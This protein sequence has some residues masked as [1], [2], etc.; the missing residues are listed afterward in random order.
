MP[1]SFAVPLRSPAPSMPSSRQR[2]NSEFVNRAL[3]KVAP[4]RSQFASAGRAETADL[5]ALRTPLDAPRPIV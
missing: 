3:E 5:A 2:L 1:S 4:R